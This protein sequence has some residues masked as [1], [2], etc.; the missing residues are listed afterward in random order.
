[1]MSTSF[2]VLVERLIERQGI[3]KEEWRRRQQRRIDELDKQL[4]QQWKEQQVTE[5]I[6]NKRCT[7]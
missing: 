5:E 4:A 2:D 3:S 6:L 1:M 7:L